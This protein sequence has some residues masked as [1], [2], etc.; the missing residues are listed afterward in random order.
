MAAM[1]SK[2]MEQGSQGIVKAQAIEDRLMRDTYEVNDYDLLPRL[3]GMRVP[4][5][6]ISGEQ[7]FVP[8]EIWEDIARAIPG[9][10][11]L[12][13]KNCGHFAY[14]ECSAEVRNALVN[15]LQSA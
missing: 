15:F 9:A 3:R 8:P 1:R 2:F 11:L 12:M 14:L 7:E 5:L 13:L 4:T 6:I 10:Q